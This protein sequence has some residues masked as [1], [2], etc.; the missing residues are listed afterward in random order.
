MLLY[1]LIITYII[2]QTVKIYL[3]IYIYIY[4]Y[5]YICDI[6]HTS[7]ASNALNNK[8]IYFP[9]ME[10]WLTIQYVFLIS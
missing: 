3:N 8:I 2:A 10:I 6:K 4:I 9:Y 1:F 7:H 5:I